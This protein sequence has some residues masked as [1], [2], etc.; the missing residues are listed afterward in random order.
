[1]GLFFTFMIRAVRKTPPPHLYSMIW[2]RP[3]ILDALWWSLGA[4]VL[5]RYL[6]TGAPH[7]W[8]VFGAIAGLGLLTKPTMLLVI[9]MVSSAIALA[10]SAPSIN[11]EST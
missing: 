4:Y 7:L 11:I 6:R 2:L 10:R 9:F 5:L 3:P 8:L 1:M